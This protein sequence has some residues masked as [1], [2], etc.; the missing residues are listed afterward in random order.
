L[1]CGSEGIAFPGDACYFGACFAGEG[2]VEG[3]DEGL[4]FG[5]ALLGG[6]DDWDEEALGLDAAAGVESVVC[7]P[8]SIRSATGADDVGEGESLGAEEGGDE[9][10]GEALGTSEG[11]G[12]LLGAGVEE[13]L[14]ALFEAEGGVFF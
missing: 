2:V 11:F 6:V 9:V 8:V 3:D 13:L 5:E 7:A 14:E 10:A 1:K 12:G 4:P